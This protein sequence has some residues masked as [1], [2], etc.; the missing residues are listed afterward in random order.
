MI[1]VGK[2]PDLLEIFIVIAAGCLPSPCQLTGMRLCL[3][4]THVTFGPVNGASG[5]QG[6]KRP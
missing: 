2:E 6:P 5:G 3:S 4:H 1:G